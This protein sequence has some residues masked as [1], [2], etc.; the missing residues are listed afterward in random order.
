MDFTLNHKETEKRNKKVHLDGV[1]L[2]FA[3]VVHARRMPVHVV[4]AA[5]RVVLVDVN[6]PLAPLCLCLRQMRYLTVPRTSFILLV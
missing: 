3:K 1:L 5:L 4:G 2:L 6:P